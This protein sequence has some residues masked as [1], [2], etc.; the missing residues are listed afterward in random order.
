[1]RDA[2]E[3]LDAMFPIEVGRGVCEIC[4]K[5]KDLQLEEVMGEALLI[6]VECAAKFAAANPATRRE[7]KNR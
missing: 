7:I 2:K 6:C 4:K 5:P 1:M 3:H